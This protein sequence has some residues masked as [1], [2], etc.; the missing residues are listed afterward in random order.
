MISNKL[1]KINLLAIIILLSVMT[2]LNAQDTYKGKYS[3]TVKFIESDRYVP[4]GTHKAFDEDENLSY[5]VKYEKDGLI[6]KLKI[7]K[8]GKEAKEKFP[9][10]INDIIWEEITEGLWINKSE[11]DNPKHTE[12]DTEQNVKLHYAGYLL[13]GDSFDSSFIRE[14]PL[15]GKLGYFVKGFSL[16]I[17]NMKEGEIRVIKIAP[18]MGYGSEKGGNVPPNSTLIYYIYLIE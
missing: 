14:K 18:S 10:S 13:N 6:R 12:F 5:T 4:I 8:D 17:T 1:L 7:N 11:I 15:H 2:Q 9:S 16:G 3:K